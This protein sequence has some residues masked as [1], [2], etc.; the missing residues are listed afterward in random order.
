MFF[1][2]QSQM[3]EISRKNFN[4]LQYNVCVFKDDVMIF[5]FR[6][7]II[8]KYD[9]III[10]KFWKN[11]FTFTTHNSMSKIFTLVYSNSIYHEKR[12]DIYFFVHKRILK[13]HIDWLNQYS[14]HNF[15]CIEIKIDINSNDVKLFVRIHNIYNFLESVERARLSH[16]S[17][18]TLLRKVLK[19]QFNDRERRVKNI[20]IDDF[21]I[22][23]LVW[24]DVKINANVKFDELLTLMN[25]YQLTQHLRRDTITW[26]S[27]ER[28]FTLNL[29]FTSIN[30]IDKV[31][32]CD[33]NKKLDHDFDHFSIKIFLDLMLIDT[34]IKTTYVW[35]KIDLERYNDKLIDLFNFISSL[36]SR[37]ALKNL[38]EHVDCF[39]RTIQE[40]IARCVSKKRINIYIISRFISKCNVR[41][42][43]WIENIC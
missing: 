13:S 31:T 11:L 12:I 39:L 14:F 5:L 18:L 41:A 34:V 1:T 20:I 23:H 15:S 19:Q 4:V 43:A 36:R 40:I 26:S 9:V 2:Q 8:L 24:D 35:D 42:P 37:L 32:H 6:D 28:S 7:E 27:R 29:C 33:I 3:L 30:L 38:N 10:Q 17:K 16:Q 22:H 25:R 21:N